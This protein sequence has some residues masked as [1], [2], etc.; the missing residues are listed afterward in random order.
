MDKKVYKSFL[1]KFSFLLESGIVDG[2]NFRMSGGEPLLE[3]DTWH[4][5]MQDFTEKY[6]GVSSAIILT[7]LSVDISSIKYEILKYKGISTS[8]DGL[9]FSKPYHSGKSSA[10]VVVS[11][12]RALISE[13]YK[14]LSITTMLNDNNFSQIPELA[15]FIADMGVPW[16]IDIDHFF[17]TSEYIEGY[18]SAIRDSLDILFDRGYDVYSKF[19]F[20]IMNLSSGNSG[21]SAGRSMFAIDTNGYV[22]PCQTS[23]GK[24][25]LFHVNDN[26]ALW[27]SYEYKKHTEYSTLDIE[28]INRCKNCPLIDICNGSCKLNRKNR[29]QDCSLYMNI[30]TYLS[31]KLINYAKL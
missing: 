20:G 4:P 9:Q 10:G 7:S 11:N 23:F 21:C 16:G 6:K 30:I 5:L 3:F 2:V 19:R 15:R 29:N 26:P 13:G 1:N 12:I 22:Y 27:I 24:K 25:P 8:L 31:T 28:N 14:K 17:T 18:K